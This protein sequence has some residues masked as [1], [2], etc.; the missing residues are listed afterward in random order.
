MFEIKWEEKAR[1]ELYKL[2]NQ[3]SSRIYKKV[4]ELKSGFQSKDIK[5]IQGENKFRLR[6]GDYR[7][8]F[9]LEN[10]LITIWKVGH[11]KNIYN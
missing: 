1:K 6:V 4:D 10:D 11:R 8:L 3:I 5:R 9:S 7:V 2:E